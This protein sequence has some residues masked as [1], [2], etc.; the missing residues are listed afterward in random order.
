MSEGSAGSDKIAM[1]VCPRLVK[2]GFKVTAYNRTYPGC[3]PKHTKYQ[4]V[5]LVHLTTTGRKGFDSFLHSL[6]ATFHIIKYNTGDI[7]KIH[8]GGNS[9]FG[10]ILKIFNK[11]VIVGQDGLDWQREKW[12]WYAKLYL[13][14]SSLITAKIPDIVLF[15]NIYALE[16]FEKR[17][18]KK[19]AFFPYGSEL[20]EIKVDNSIL[21][22][23][24]IEPNEYFLFVGRFIP[25]KG[26]QYLIPAFENIQT[27]KKLVL[28][29][30]SP[31]PSNFEN[32]ILNTTSNRI[33]SPGYIYGK[34]VFNLMKNAYA[35]IQ[36]SDVEGLSPV[37]LEVMGLQTPLICSDIQENLYIVKRDALTFK[38]SNIQ[39]L[40]MIMNYALQ[41]PTILKNNAIK[42]KIRIEKE[43]S[44]D[45]YTDNFINLILSLTKGK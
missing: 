13:Y 39:D 22:K 45:K 21:E 14:L 43:Y 42:A 35:Y 28:V 26:L 18:N 6:K 25:D 8:N 4:G 19:Y 33:I 9:I 40:T 27:S 16:Y 38:K 7:I 23:L 31:N 36:P 24:N 37:I 1:E 12:S 2:R 15:D 32:E 30:G 3:I 29:G 11:K 10:V 34:D 41:N 5:H 17:Y 44:W 20:P